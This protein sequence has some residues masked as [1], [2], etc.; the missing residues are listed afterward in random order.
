MST[1]LSTDKLSAR[2]AAFFQDTDREA[3]DGAR[4]RVLLQLV[5][6]IGRSAEAAGQLKLVFVCTHNSRRS[7]LSEAIA[8]A[9]AHYTGQSTPLAVY[10]AGTAATRVHP[11]ALEALQSIGFQ[12]EGLVEGR[13]NPNEPL[14]VTPFE[15]ADAEALTL[16]SKTLA[17]SSL[18]KQ[19]FIA[20]MT[21][22]EA[23]A[24]CPIVPGAAAR[25]KLPYLDPKAADG[26]P[27][28]AQAYRQLVKQ[29]A[30]EWLFVW[31]KIAP[32]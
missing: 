12:V 31:R 4:E 29:L 23:D 26:T 8:F 25:I 15:R 21:C 10:S 17:H 5:E 18:P 1:P 2:L 11:H 9:A 27:Q 3:F 6:A 19:N 30:A 20:V 14:R 28:A 7:Q 24:A 13:D 16:F 22:E 32:N